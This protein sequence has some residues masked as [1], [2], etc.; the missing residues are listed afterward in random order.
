M[1]LL[2]TQNLK[3][4]MRNAAELR[5]RPGLLYSKNYVSGHTV[6]VDNIAF[7]HNKRLKIIDT[8]LCYSV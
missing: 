4:K 8:R 2:S 3:S 7:A 5:N 1:L 6:V